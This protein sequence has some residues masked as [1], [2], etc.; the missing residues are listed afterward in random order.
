MRGQCATLTPPARKPPCSSRLR[1]SP[2]IDN[3]TPQ[4]R[5]PSAT[6]AVPLSSLVSPRNAVPDDSLATIFNPLQHG[7]RPRTSLNDATA[8]ATATH[9][10]LG[11]TWTTVSPVYP[12][13]PHSSPLPTTRLSSCPHTAQPLPNHA[14]PSHN[15]PTETLKE[16][17]P[18]VCVTPAQLQAWP[19][20]AELTP[21]SVAA[22]S[23][24]SSRAPQTATDSSYVHRLEEQVRE[25]ERFNLGLDKKVSAHRIEHVGVRGSTGVPDFSGLL[26]TDLNGTI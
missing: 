14:S 25:L 1:R 17:F 3:E 11:S 20:Q 26:S 4:Y 10:P 15:S 21:S 19:A 8:K 24:R 16:V 6:T 9:C 23:G 18:P 22:H 5:Y 12:S 2:S 7:L 13:C